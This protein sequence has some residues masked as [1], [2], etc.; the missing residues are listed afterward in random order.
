MDVNLESSVVT[1]INIKNP[2]AHCFVAN[3]CKNVFISKITIDIKDGEKNG[4]H[5][6]DGI[7][8]G[9]STN[10]TVSG[11]KIWNQDD[12]FCSG[13][14]K[15]ITIENF[16]CNGSGHGMSIGSM[17]GGK[18]VENY[19][20]RNSKINGNTNAIRIKTRKG[21]T[22]LVKNVRFEN[23]EMKDITKVGI[24]VQSNYLNA[25]PTGDPTPF[26]IED[27]VINNVYG[28]VHSKGINMQ[29]WVAPGSAKNWTWKSNVTGGQKEVACKGIPAGLNIPC[30]KKQ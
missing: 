13:S 26:P 23:I 10:V 4:G 18:K 7:G 27:L 3:N 9:D 22:G 25:G 14:G 2:P 1:G 29:V 11:A 15:D 21:E 19:I 5:N 30:G 6:T 17:G 28:T 20:I 8:V 16:E 12:C 24:L